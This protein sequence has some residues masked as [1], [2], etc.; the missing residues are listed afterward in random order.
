VR[1]DPGNH[2]V[3]WQLDCPPLRA[4]A[5]VTRLALLA[6]GALTSVDARRRRRRAG[7]RAS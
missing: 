6:A 7:A 1:L 3:A 2:V 5:A 4:G